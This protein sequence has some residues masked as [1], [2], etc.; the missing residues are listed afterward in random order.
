MSYTAH[1]QNQACSSPSTI[2]KWNNLTAIFL[3]NKKKTFIQYIS[4]WEGNKKTSSELDDYYR[5][6][7]LMVG[8]ISVIQVG[9]VQRET[10]RMMQSK[11]N[12]VFMSEHCWFFFFFVFS[13]VCVC[14]C[15]FVMYWCKGTH[16]IL[17]TVRKFKYLDVLSIKV[18][19]Q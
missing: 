18:N 10:N 6:K 1:F 14:V 17:I 11:V 13:F 2:N 9:L 3:A 19:A 15:V 7:N 16:F 8:S 4:I 12:D 5:Q